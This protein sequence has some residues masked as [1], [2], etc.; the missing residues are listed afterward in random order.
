MAFCMHFLDS[1]SIR[2]TGREKKVLDD[3]KCR[4]RVGLRC[5]QAKITP[6]LGPGPSSADVPCT[7]MHSW[8]MSQA[9]PEASLLPRS[10]TCGAPG[11]SVPILILRNVILSFWSCAW[12]SRPPTRLLLAHVHPLSTGR[13][14]AAYATAS[15][16]LSQ[17][18]ERDLPH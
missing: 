15:E 3:A 16:V 8:Q 2:A 18:P 4:C 10:P 7:A 11:S 17:C 14:T 12:L 9:G 5:S 1:R 13:K 6:L